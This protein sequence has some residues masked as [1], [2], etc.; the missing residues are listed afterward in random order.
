MIRVFLFFFILWANVLSVN[1]QNTDLNFKYRQ[2]DSAIA[3]SPVYVKQYEKEIQATHIQFINAKKDNDRYTLSFKLYQ[4]YKS[5]M[6]DSAIVYLDRCISLAEKLNRRDL[7]GDCRALLAFQCSSSGL[8]TEA[9]NI[10][11]KISLGDLNHKGVCDY[12]IAYIHVYGELG[13]YTKIESMRTEYLALSSRYKDAFYKVADPNSQ[14]YLLR[15][16][17]DFYNQKE[18][19]KALDVN[20]KWLAKVKPGSREYA[21]VAF[22]RY[23]IYNIQGDMEMSKRWLLESAITDTRH[24]VMDQASLWS[25]ASILNDEGDLRRSYSY[26]RFTWDCNNR[27]S[28]RMRNWQISPVLSLIDSN[29][30][31]QIRKTNR[32][33]ISS[34]IVVSVLS[35]LLLALLFFLYAQ[36]KKLSVARNELKKIN[37][38]LAGLNEKLSTA[39]ANLDISNRQLSA[40]NDKLSVS[41]DRLNESN[42]VKEE[43]IGRFLSLCSQYVD[44]LDN[45]RKMVNRK[46]K[47]KELDELFTISKSTE[48]KEKEIEELYA[49]FDS[50]FIHLF[51]SF[52]DDFNA[53]LKPEVQSHPKDMS[54]LTTDL[55][56]FALIRLGID[57][58]SKIAEFLHYSV[59]TIY[60]Y[61]ARI[62]N[63][64]LTDRENFERRVKKLGLISG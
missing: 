34:I 36:K 24:A 16:D 57:D 23:L 2:L 46:M 62:K 30:Q 35:L 14:D 43:Y 39:N 22:Y 56:I 3:E 51:P 53:M 55:R 20:S 61:R 25:L 18:Y 47:N 6:N 26:I 52:V 37:E 13:Y 28:T 10:L 12:Y 44:K 42:R 7:A 4:L 8:Y 9:L 41:N 58:S 45:Y 48:F 63:G 17:V 15:K 32:E 1:A 54:H 21:I 27:F 64:A 60:N 11:S 33:L 50:V 31:N 59:N 49:N 40:T 19:G 5:F 29:Y 38:K